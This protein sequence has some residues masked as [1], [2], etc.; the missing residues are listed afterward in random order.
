MKWCMLAPV[1]ILAACAMDLDSVDPED[2]GEES[3]ALDVEC[4]MA[5][6]TAIFNGGANYLSGAHYDTPN[7][8][9][10]VVIDINNYSAEF[11]GPGNIPGGTV[12]S[13]PTGAAL[14]QARCGSS[15][16]KAYLFEKVNN[17]WVPKKSVFES[18]VWVPPGGLW[19]NGYCAWP[20]V[21][22]T[23]ADLQAGKSYR[24]AASNREAV[25]PFGITTHQVSV[26][27]VKPL[28]I[29]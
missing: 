13:A 9:K 1:V 12:V 6:P 28:V 17:D 29:N 23:A 20:S 8:W 10:A 18:A 15:W 14:E 3:Q 5:N 27:S 16:T 4:A 24:V 7:C 11:L 25:P 22:F 19:P 26:K 2:I 21:Q